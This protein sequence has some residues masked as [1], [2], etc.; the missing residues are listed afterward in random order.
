M[1]VVCSFEVPMAATDENLHRSNRINIM[2]MPMETFS[3]QNRTKLR[4]RLYVED[5]EGE[6]GLLV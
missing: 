1:M 3:E 2:H 5:R 6:V 4:T